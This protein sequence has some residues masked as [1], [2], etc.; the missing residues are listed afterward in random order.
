MSGQIKAGKDLRIDRCS[1]SFLFSQPA[2]NFIQWHP[3]DFA[4]FVFAFP[5]AF[6]NF[7]K[8]SGAKE[9]D[10]LIAEAGRRR[11]AAQ[12]FPFVRFVTSLLIQSAFSGSVNFLS[13]IGFVPG[14]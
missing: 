7:S 14:Q 4:L 5:A 6:P 1:V 11:A 10:L 3:M 12:L 8:F 2:S 9:N 13:V